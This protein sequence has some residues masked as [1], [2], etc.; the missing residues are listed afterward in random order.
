MK[1]V[2]QTQATLGSISESA[3]KVDGLV[4]GIAV[5]TREQAVAL[6]TINSAVADL[7]IGVHR[8]T[9]M[10]EASDQACRCLADDA[11]SLTE[12]VGR[13]TVSKVLRVAA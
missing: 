11:N 4:A 1:L 10:A 13:F 8:N 9:R 2:G 12:L 5:S 6:Q 3:L 7:G